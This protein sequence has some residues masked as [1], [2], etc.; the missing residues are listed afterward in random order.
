M[1]HV[2]VERLIM[3]QASTHRPCVTSG[4][5]IYKV[6]TK[7]R[8]GLSQLASAAS[9]ILMRLIWL[10]RLDRPDLLRVVT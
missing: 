7:W 5:L 1:Q 8:N 10:A 9:S 3:T 6:I 4:R 2:S